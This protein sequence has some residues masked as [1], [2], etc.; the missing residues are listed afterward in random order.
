MYVPKLEI[1]SAARYKTVG[2]LTSAFYKAQKDVLLTGIDDK[3]L[4]FFARKYLKKFFEVTEG[5]VRGA[6]LD[7]DP[8]FFLGWRA[9][10]AQVDEAMIEAGCQIPE[11]WSIVRAQHVL[12]LFQMI[13]NKRL[14]ALGGKATDGQTSHTTRQDS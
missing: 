10:L 5:D 4:P 3:K 1:P 14:V 6:L 11:R 12:D 8:W 13:A 2:G 9:R 7:G